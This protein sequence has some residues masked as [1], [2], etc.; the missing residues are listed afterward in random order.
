MMRTHLLFIPMFLSALPL[1]VGGDEAIPSKA[2]EAE[3]YRNLWSNS[4]FLR[5][6]NAAESFSLTGVIRYDGKPTITMLNTATGERITLSTTS[7]PQGWRLI[8][9][10]EDPNPR[11]VTARV[12]VNGEEV[13]V[14]FNDRQLSTDALV[15]AASGPGRALPLPTPKPRLSTPREPLPKKDPPP[16][17]REVDSRKNK[18][19]NR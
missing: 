11:N 13:A 18:H 1:A 9:L 3:R 10:T 12:I 7:N 8:D 15:K 16:K 4:P 17:P 14:R 5:P 19:Q 6:L 2:P